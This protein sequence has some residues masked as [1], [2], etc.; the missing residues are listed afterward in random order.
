M[1]TII[2]KL[3]Q[4]SPITWI[5]LGIFT[6]LIIISLVIGIDSDRGV[7]VGWLANI[8]LLI[9]VTRRWRKDWQFLLLAAGAF[10]GAILLSGLHE[11]VIYPLVEK[12]GG[13]GALNSPGMNGFHAVITDIILIF[14]PMTII[15]G[16]M[17]A[18]TLFIVRL[19][20]LGRKKASE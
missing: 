1:K 8:V 18:V 19:V 7:L 2:A 5:M 16:I 12:I 14:T 10:L 15:F 9:E 4:V 17:G 11:A 3:K 20:T 13:A 6:G